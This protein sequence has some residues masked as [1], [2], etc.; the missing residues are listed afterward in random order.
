MSGIPA[1]CGWNNAPLSANF[2]GMF[3][4]DTV[5]I[6]WSS[7]PDPAYT[8]HMNQN[9]SDSIP[10]LHLSNSADALFGVQIQEGPDQRETVPFH[11]IRT[12]RMS[13]MA[14]GS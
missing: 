2:S 13:T 5:N 9:I 14:E 12:F 7:S 4:L 10:Q 8:P 1:W 11:G 6:S 3:S